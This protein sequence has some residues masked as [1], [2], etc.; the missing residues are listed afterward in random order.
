MH[1][2]VFAKMNNK[3][4]VVLIFPLVLLTI[5]YCNSIEPPPPPSPEP[6]KEITLTLE[7]ISA[8][9]AWIRLTTTNMQ[10]PDTVTLKQNNIIRS[11]INLVNS[12]TLLY[13]D[14]LL[15]GTNYSYVAETREVIS[16]TL[17]VRTI[18]TTSHNFTWQTFEFGQHSSSLLYDVAIINENNIWS[19]GEIYLNDSLGHT[20]RYNAI[21]WDGSGWNIKRIPF[22][23]ECSA[24]IYPPIRSVFAFSENDIW[25]ARG[26]SLVHFNG[27]NY[28]ND[29]GMNSFL[30]GSINKIWGISSEDLF[31]VGNNGNI[32][33]YNGTSWQKIESGT[34]L[35]LVDVYGKNEN[36]I[37]ISGAY[38]PEIKGILLRGNS[39]QFSVMINSE[40]IS[41]NELF[42][43]LYGELAIVWVDELGTVYTGGNILFRYK[44][45]EWNYVRS[46]PENFIGGNP[47][48]YY[49]GFISSIRGIASNDYIIAGDRNTLKHFNGV[50]WEQIG[51]PYS[52]SSPIIWYSVEMKGNTAIAVGDKGSN[53]FIILLKR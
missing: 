52:P 18:D 5:F 24:V 40:I 47:G 21:H 48:T 28:F 42:D 37:Y 3:V 32:A 50:T 20:V 26:G 36:E 41:E 7:D 27:V 33:H 35:P 39:N 34:E 30:T 8:V 12:D 11:T 45:N 25:F 46:L 19:V 44:N 4:V 10:Q 51:L 1:N 13:I 14:S 16:E 9:E 2:E 43:K 49:R 6:E 15:P 17:E 53:A 29:C 22:T 23:G 38:T 31:I